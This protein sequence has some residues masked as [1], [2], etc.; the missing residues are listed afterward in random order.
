[1][2]GDVWEWTSSDFRAYPGF[3]AFPYPEYS[4]VFFGDST[5]SCAAAPGRPA[6]TSPAPSFRNW[7]LP[8]RRQI[9]SGVPTPARRVQSGQA[10]D[11]ITDSR[12][13]HDRGPSRRRPG[14]RRPRAGRARGPLGDFK[15]LPPKYFY[16]ERGSELFE[17]ITELDEYYPTR[18]ERAILELHSP[19]IAAAADACN[20]IELGSGSA[21]KT[22]VLLD[23]MR[24]AGCLETY[25]PV[26]ISEEITRATAE[27]LVDEY[28]GLRVHG[29]V[30]DFERHLELLPR[31]APPDRLPR[32]HDRQLRSRGRAPGSWP[33]SQPLLGPRRPP[34]ARH[35]PGQGPARLEAAYDDAQGVTAEFNKNVL[36]VLNR[37]LRRR[38]RPRRLR[39]PR[40]LR[41][42]Q[43]L[44]R[45]PPALAGQTRWC[46]RP[47]AGDAGS[48]S[49][50]GEEM[51]TEISAPSSPAPAW[52]ESTPK[53]A[54]R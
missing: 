47:G 39:A 40:L 30:C 44:G 19:A 13:G 14:R 29:V 5:R 25:V 41:R 21:S 23:A 15:E 4:E 54:S 24:D 26:D 51:R 12:A 52:S 46:R 22:R 17:Q 32:G 11:P 37:E 9:F 38:L 36:H 7:D 18:A 33:G 3:E 48:S 27:S 2:L 16:D 49:R 42:R 8:E 31:R 35:R 43:R 1:M 34:P 10:M 6:A 45:H 53:P 20:L 50:R 28:P